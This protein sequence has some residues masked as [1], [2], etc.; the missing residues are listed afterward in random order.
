MK[1]ILKT[2]ENLEAYVIGYNEAFLRTISKG[3]GCGY[4]KVTSEH[5]FYKLAKIDMILQ[6]STNFYVNFSNEITLTEL[7][8]EH[9]IIG[10]DTAHSW[11]SAETSNKQMVENTTLELFN[12]ADSFTNRDLE[13]YKLA[14]IS[15]YSK[16]INNV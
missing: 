9:L 10:F 5:P 4:I 8:Q 7:T 12:I 16:M 2:T 3:W 13:I 14:K 6:D 11:D 15:E 1:T